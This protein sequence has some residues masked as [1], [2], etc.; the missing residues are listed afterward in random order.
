[1][2]NYLIVPLDQAST[3]FCYYANPS[4]GIKKSKLI[5]FN[6]LSRIVKYASENSLL[7]N[8]L[9]GYEPLDEKY[10]KLIARSQHVKIVPV[11]IL[12]RFKEED[13]TVVINED[14]LDLAQSIED[15][16][17]LNL[18]L[19]YPKSELKRLAVYIELLMNKCRRINLSLLHIHEYKAGDL[20][21]YKNQLDLIY[22]IVEDHYLSGHSVEVSFVSDRIILSEMNNCNAGL[23][24]LTIGFNG[25]FYV[26]PGFY[27]DDVNNSVGDLNAG[28]NIQNSQLLQ[29]D[30]APICRNCD[31]FHCKRCIYLN[32]KTTLEWNTPS[33]EQCVISHLERNTSKSLLDNLNTRLEV[34]HDVEPIPEINYLDPFDLVKTTPG[35][36]SIVKKGLT[37]AVTEK[38]ED[39]SDREL[40]L[41]ILEQQEKILQLL[42]TKNK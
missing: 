5:P 31:A 4:S 21:E 19:R 6:T 26:C 25:K 34:F 9:Y 15:N 1:M 14:E 33:H 20:E 18:I 36:K 12:D 41:K 27:Y 11:N 8:Y 29:L 38:Y 42:K 37:K 23:T 22:D 39:K 2:I 35:N 30:H 13:V 28:V 16:F 17:S 3:S 10:N 40:L 24:H 7:I 32:Q